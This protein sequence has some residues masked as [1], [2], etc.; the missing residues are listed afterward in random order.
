MVKRMTKTFSFSKM[1]ANGANRHAK[2]LARHYLSRDINSQTVVL[3]HRS[4]PDS[5]SL[6]LQFVR[7]PLVVARASVQK[8]IPV[9]FFATQIAGMKLRPLEVVSA[10]N[11][12][13][14]DDNPPQHAH[15]KYLEDRSA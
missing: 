5:K 8:I 10:E 6:R 4:T 7:E 2:R 12:E 13:Q 9:A 15:D 11:F 14:C 1:A 3:T